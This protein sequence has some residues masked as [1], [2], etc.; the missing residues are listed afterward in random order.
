MRDKELHELAAEGKTGFK[1]RHPLTGLGVVDDERMAY[2]EGCEAAL[3][4]I[5]NLT[6]TAHH[7][8]GVALVRD[9]ARDALSGD[10]VE[11]AVRDAEADASPEHDVEFKPDMPRD[12]YNPNCE[13]RP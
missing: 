10:V 9:I 7:L 2:L 13:V 5:V 8:G 11:R 12:D 1:P 6:V 4:R 3:E